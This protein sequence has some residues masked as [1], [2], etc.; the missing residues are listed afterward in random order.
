MQDLQKIFRI[1]HT[2]EKNFKSQLSDIL[3][4]FEVNYYIIFEHILCTYCVFTN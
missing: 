2:I 1:A 4:D 3:S